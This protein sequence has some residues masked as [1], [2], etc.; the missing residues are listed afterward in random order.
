[1]TRFNRKRMEKLK[2]FLQMF[3]GSALTPR[4]LFVIIPSCFFHKLDAIPKK[5]MPKQ[6]EQKL[7]PLMEPYNAI[8]KQRP[9]SQ[10]I[11][12][13]YFHCAKTFC[14]YLFGMMPIIPFIFSCQPSAKQEQ[15]STMNNNM[16]D[17][18]AVASLTPT[19][20]KEYPQAVVN[21]LELPLI[22]H[23]P[24]PQADLRFAEIINSPIDSQD[25]WCLT[26]YTA[27]Y[28]LD[29]R[30]NAW[31]NL[32]EIIGKFAID[33]TGNRVVRDPFDHDL[34]WIFKF[35]DGI[36]RYHIPTNLTTFLDVNTY[37]PNRSITAVVL[38]VHDVW[39]GS[40]NG[41]YR[42]IRA[43]K[44]LQYVKGLEGQWLEQL[45]LESG[46]LQINNNIFFDPK[47]GQIK[48]SYYGN[49][50]T[51]RHNPSQTPVL[52][53]SIFTYFASGEGFNRIHK[54]TLDEEVF[55]LSV[56]RTVMAD[57][58]FFWIQTHE[59]IIRLRKFENTEV[60]LSVSELKNP[61]RI[62]N[63]IVLQ[64]KDASNINERLEKIADLYSIPEFVEHTRRWNELGIAAGNN[65]LDWKSKEA[66]EFEAL[67]IWGSFE[68]EAT[69]RLVT[70]EATEVDSVLHFLKT[71]RKPL[72]RQV[73]YRFL[74]GSSLAFENLDLALSYWEKL[75]S[76]YP[77][78]PFL[79]D[80]DMR[81][82]TDRLARYK[83]IKAQ[84]LTPDE[85]LWKTAQLLL[86]P[87]CL[88]WSG[89]RCYGQYYAGKLFLELIDKYPYSPRRGD[90]EFTLIQLDEDAVHD[91]GDVDSSCVIQYK[92]FIQYYPHHRY[93]P[94]AMLE[95]A[96][97][98]WSVADVEAPQAIPIFQMAKP[99]FENLITKFPT[100]VQAKMA[101]DRLLDIHR[102]Q[103][104][105]HAP[106]LID[107]YF[108]AQRYFVGDSVK[109]KLW[110]VSYSDRDIQ[111]TIY[112]DSLHFVVSADWMYDSVSQPALFIPD[113]TI[114]SRKKPAEKHILEARGGGWGGETHNLQQLTRTK[115]GYGRFEFN[116]PGWYWI[117]FN[118]NLNDSLTVWSLCTIEFVERKSY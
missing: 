63:A 6:E 21:W 33:L 111:M 9:N 66:Q 52:E 64:L 104:N 24:F 91:C 83:E 105:E 35:Y 103:L 82:I 48:P 30:T 29:P 40:T 17:S 28:Q 26:N 36:L 60:F 117:Q 61:K 8:K 32:T 5:I 94:Q 46:L 15:Q 58:H 74:I 47:S 10:M 31:T 62:A 70:L 20:Q 18:E 92:R 97:H 51:T 14:V 106:Y 88:N 65:L 38:D 27:S 50:S 100:A 75:R 25:V 43:S 56:I 71:R 4:R 86:D 108:D 73:A 107:V 7:T 78:S 109:V 13:T 118:L 115:D 112:P 76:E 45:S 67:G 59:E 3:N 93:I 116:H 90:A 44:E 39:I 101:R 80:R 12:R 42:Y 22:T 2:A 1:M 89:H 54:R 55:P 85:K 49:L 110:L 114:Q 84:N 96:N 69:Q 102:K 79:T 11:A 72:E 99:Y 57:P 41:L 68:R 19:M 37:F 87:L 77:Q 16:P 53:D 95:I 34:I 23:H 98:Y 113:L 81:A